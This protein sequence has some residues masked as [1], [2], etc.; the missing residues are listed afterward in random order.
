MISLLCCLATAAFPQIIIFA[1]IL[2]FFSLPQ[3]LYPQIIMCK[4]FIFCLLYGIVLLNCLERF[5]VGFYAKT[6]YIYPSASLF[7]L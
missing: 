3:H 5:M 6:A 4:D 1:K 7:T 2:K